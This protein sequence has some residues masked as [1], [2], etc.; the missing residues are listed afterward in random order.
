MTSVVWADALAM[1]EA[2]QVVQ[3]GDRLTIYPLALC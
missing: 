1:V 3:P 2:G